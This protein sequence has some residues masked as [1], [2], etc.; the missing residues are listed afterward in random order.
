MLMAGMDEMGNPA[1]G[2]AV[3]SM[4]SLVPAKWMSAVG[5]CDLTASA[6]A[7]AGY[8]WPPVPPAANRME[9][10]FLTEVESVI[11]PPSFFTTLF[12]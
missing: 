4:R 1:A 11:L 3:H 9:S 2:T 6:I 8:T 12:P 5:S 7:M 10:G